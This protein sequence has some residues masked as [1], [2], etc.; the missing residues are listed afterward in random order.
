M[1]VNMHEAKSQ[2]SQLGRLAWEGKE[3]VIARSGVPYL[4]L[5]PYRQPAADRTPGSMKGEIWI[6]ADFDEY[7]ERFRNPQILSDEDH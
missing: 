5:E 6:A 7:D 1:Q 3:I 2:L 4:R